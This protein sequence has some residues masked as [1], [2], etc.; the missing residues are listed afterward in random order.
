[1]HQSIKQV[2]RCYISARQTDWEDLLPMC[3]FSLNSSYSA[4]TGCSPAYVVYSREPVLPLEHALRAAVD[5]KVKRV[6]ERV[7]AME[8]VVTSAY[9]T[10]A[11]VADYMSHYTNFCRRDLAIDV[12]SF[13]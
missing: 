11:R 8:Q 10:I 13:A 2:L 1:M 4:T 12:R 7:H 5:C 6:A 9:V 3:E